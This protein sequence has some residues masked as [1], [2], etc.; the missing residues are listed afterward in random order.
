M[1]IKFQM[2]IKE[3]ASWLIYLISQYKA[4]IS[5]LALLCFILFLFI[6]LYQFKDIIFQCLFSQDSPWG[7]GSY[8]LVR[9]ISA[10][11]TTTYSLIYI[12]RIWYKK[13]VSNI[14]EGIYISLGDEVLKTNFFQT[15]K[16]SSS[17][18][19]FP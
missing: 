15:S 13:R 18:L 5:I 3:E 16:E 1:H 9:K 14:P 7:L 2:L 19:I 11:E 12:G 17:G 8:C 6:L 10:T 4:F